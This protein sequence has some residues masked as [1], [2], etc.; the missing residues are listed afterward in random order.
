VITTLLTF[1]PA[2]QAAGADGAGLKPGQCSWADRPMNER[3]LIRFET[4]ANAQLKQQLHGTPLDTSPTA[5]ERFPDAQT[6]PIYLRDSRHYWSF[7]GARPVNNFFIAT[8]NRYWRPAVEVRPIDS[9]RNRDRPYVLSPQ[10]QR[11]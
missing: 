3:F 7:F 5:A 8:G 10:T 4:P 2:P 11:G 6:I 9:K 1:E